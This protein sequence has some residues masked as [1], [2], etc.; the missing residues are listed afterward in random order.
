LI[1]LKPRQA[2]QFIG[3]RRCE[4]MTT[5]EPPFVITPEWL[6]DTWAT[7]IRRYG[8]SQVC[9]KCTILIDNPYGSP[10]LS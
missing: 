7:A 3:A 8:K 10:H 2:E 1:A 5:P 4:V 6:Q 9:G